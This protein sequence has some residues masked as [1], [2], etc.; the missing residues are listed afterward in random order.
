[1]SEFLNQQ[2]MKIVYKSSDHEERQLEPDI[3]KSLERKGSRLLRASQLEKIDEF[4]QICDSE[5]KGYITATDMRV[6]SWNLFVICVWE[7]KC[8]TS[9]T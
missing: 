4:F 8:M 3:M 7:E 1:M 6:M 2:A 9:Y 5:G